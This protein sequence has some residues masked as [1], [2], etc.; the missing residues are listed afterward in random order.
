MSEWY[1]NFGDTMK[2]RKVKK[3]FKLLIIL[4]LIVAAAIIFKNV[5]MKK[6]DHKKIENKKDLS[7]FIS[8]SD[9]NEKYENSYYDIKYVEKK[10]FLKNVNILLDKGYTTDEIN[11]VFEHLSDKNISKLINSERLKL[12]EFYTIKN[13]NVDNYDRYVN[14]KKSSGISDISKIV[15]Y[16]NIDLDKPDYTDMNTIADPDN[17]FVIVNKHNKLPDGYVPKDLVAYNKN[18][19]LRTTIKKVMVDSLTEFFNAAVKDGH[20]LYQTTSYRDYNWQNNL[21]TSYVNRDGKEKADTYSARPGNSEHQ[22]GY[23]IDLAN[24]DLKNTRLT[25]EDALWIKEN[26]YKYGFILRYTEEN[27]HITRYIAESWHIRYVGLDA[28]KIIHEN[29]LTLEEYVDLYIKEY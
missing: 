5:N 22:T 9:Y 17:F 12:D 25:D 26:C 20:N 7:V 16:V 3:T 21:Y 6:D 11:R 13:F 19:S 29:N 28:A 23:A 1:N 10:D 8:D 14:Y 27:K 4:F 15:T 18:N 24:S 2:K